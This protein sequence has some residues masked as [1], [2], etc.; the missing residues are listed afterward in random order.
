V[1][2]GPGVERIA[3]EVAELFPGRRTIVLS[4][5]F[6]GGTERLRAELADDV[7]ALPGLLGWP[8]PVWPG[9]P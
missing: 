6:P 4:S 1:A 3:E 2:C 8:A 5:D 9:W 7:V